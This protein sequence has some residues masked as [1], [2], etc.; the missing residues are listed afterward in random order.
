[1]SEEEQ[2][3]EPRAVVRHRR[4]WSSVWVVPLVAL[5]LAGW[6]VWKHYHDKGE[7]AYVRF[8]TADSIE[9]GKTEVRCRSVKVGVVEKIE[10]ADDLLSVVTEI[11]IDPD[12]ADL[13]RGGSRLWVVRPRVS[14]STISGLSTL[15]TGAYIELEPGDGPAPVNHFDGLEQPPVTSANVPGLRLTL[16]AEDAGSLTANSPIYYRGFEVGRVERRTLDIENR[17]VRF[18]VF[19]DDDY[20]DL[21]RQGTC[22]WNTSGIDVTAGADG[23][24]L[25]TPSLQAMVTGGASFSVPKGGVSGGPVTDGTVFTLF[26]DEDAAK[27]SIFV[28]DHLCLLFFDQSVRGLSTGAPVEFRGIPIGRVVEISFK[29]SPSGDSRVPVV[30]EIDSDTLAKAVENIDNSKNVL[31]ECVRRGLRATLSTGSLLTGALYVDL[32]FVPGAAPAELARSG[33]Y[34]IIP[35]ESSGFAQLQDKLNSILSKIEALPLDETLGKFGNAADEIAITVKDVRSTLDEA[36]AALAEAKKLLARDE[37]QNITAELEATLKEV[38]S[39]VS[40]L[41]PEGAVQ[42]DLSRTLDELRAALRAFKTLS[43]SIEGKPNSLLFGRESSGNKEPKA[44]KR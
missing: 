4:R 21:V 30:I 32:D 25:S 23:F 43:D 33:E 18:D 3:Q 28:P 16:V 41:G 34:E 29:H 31:E 1:M 20:S 5:V 22:F 37:T 40:S 6:L 27:K 15:I 35:T 14:A 19:I 26:T 8:L 44:K 2:P 7:L 24:K 17:R 11:R 36:E 13:L 42:G 39:S 9:A 12:S 10:L 38:R